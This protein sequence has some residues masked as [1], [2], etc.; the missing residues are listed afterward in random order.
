M[1]NFETGSGVFVYSNMVK[2]LDSQKKQLTN[3]NGVF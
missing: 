2:S 3:T 1:K